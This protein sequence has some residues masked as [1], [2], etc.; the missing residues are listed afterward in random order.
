MTMN[1]DN[2][3]NVLL[4][5]LASLNIPGA[6]L[7]I[8]YRRTSDRPIDATDTWNNME[9]ALRYARNTDAEAYVP[10][11]GQAIS[12]KGD[13][14]LYLLVEDETISKEDGRNHFKLHKVSTEEVASSRI[15]TGGS[16]TAA[17][18]MESSW[19][20]PWDSPE[21]SPDRTVL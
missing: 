12:V 11:F 10:Y 20:C 1:K 4:S 19:R 17:L 15:M 21:P 9:D 5:G 18:A 7:A 13:K 14:S 16:A 6:S 3:V 8:Q 2:L